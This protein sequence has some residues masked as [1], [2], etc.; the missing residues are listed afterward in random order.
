MHVDLGALQPLDKSDLGL[1]SDGNVEGLV[2]N[3]DVALVVEENVLDKD[4]GD[5]GTNHAV[6]QSIKAIVEHED[7]LHVELL[8]G[9]VAGGKGTSAP[10]KEFGDLSHHFGAT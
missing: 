2:V 5:L 3:F 10:G 7:V 1:V 8:H 4:L 6:V 9:H